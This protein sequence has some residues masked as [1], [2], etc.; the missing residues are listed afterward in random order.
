MNPRPGWLAL[1]T[2]F[3]GAADRGA[4]QS[5]QWALLTPVLILAIIGM[6]QYAV[7]LQ[8]QQAAS[9]AAMMGAE[10]QARHGARPG[11]GTDVASTSAEEA[12][13]TA[14]SATTQYHG[15]LV[16]V[17]VTGR[18]NLFLD[19]G[20]GRITRRATMPLERP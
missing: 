12:G 16:T 19:L 14:V 8:A 15:G 7:I 9:T 18:A 4:S 2:R 11:A 13:L 17:T 6:I 5:L 3:R 20:Q 10:A 1:G